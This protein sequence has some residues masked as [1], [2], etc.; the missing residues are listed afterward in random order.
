MSSYTLGSRC[1]MQSGRDQSCNN[2]LISSLLLGLFLKMDSSQRG[3]Q[4][5]LLRRENPPQKI[6]V[7]VITDV[8][9]NRCYMNKSLQ[10]K[11]CYYHKHILHK[12]HLYHH[13]ATVF[14][15]IYL[16]HSMEHLH[17]LPQ[18]CLLILAEG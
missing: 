9:V 3:V 1:P 14:Y 12:I 13:K 11:L 5:S 17:D 6:N 7:I 2:Y 4:W 8:P 10:I 15:F 18:L 16:I